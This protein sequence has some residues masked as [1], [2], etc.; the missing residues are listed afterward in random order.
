MLSSQ[1][2]ADYLGLLKRNGQHHLPLAG[3]MKKGE[4][5]GFKPI[6]RKCR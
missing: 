4:N 3:K 6:E 1:M 2:R 5:D